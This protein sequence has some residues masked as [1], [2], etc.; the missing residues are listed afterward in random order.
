MILEAKRKKFSKNPKHNPK[1]D[2]EILSLLGKMSQ[3]N[4]ADRFDVSRQRITQI[5]QRSQQIK[6]KELC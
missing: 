5:K 3:T 4:I 1:R 6:T 2:K